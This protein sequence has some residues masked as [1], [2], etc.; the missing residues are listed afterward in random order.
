MNGSHK[1]PLR[2][3]QELAS[4]PKEPRLEVPMWNTEH[5]ASFWH[6]ELVV[7]SH[8]ERL[9]KRRVHFPENP[10]DAL[11]SLPFCMNHFRIR[12]QIWNSL[13]PAV[14][15]RDAALGKRQRPDQGRFAFPLHHQS[16]IQYDARQ[17]SPERRPALETAQVAIRRKKRLLHRVFRVFSIPQNGL[18]NRE[19]SLAGCD[20]HLLQSVLSEDILSC[21]DESG[22]PVACRLRRG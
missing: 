2:P 21:L 22:G 1:S 14:V 8:R 7:V 17:P 16:R 20:K 18:R 13:R 5:G 19:E 15:L 11:K 4:C 12:L 9:S 6:R 3:I 10:V